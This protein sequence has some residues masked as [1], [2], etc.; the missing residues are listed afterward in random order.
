MT[1]PTI[2]LTCRDVAYAGFWNMDECCE[3]CHYDKEEF[4]IEMC[5]YG[6]A[7]RNKRRQESRFRIE[8]CCA[9]LSGLRKCAES[10]RDIVA[11]AAWGRH[12]R[13]R[14]WAEEGEDA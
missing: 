12:E 3:T 4:D 7:P 2:T 6:D 14:A 13:L 1:R 8:L 11:A 5:E 9:C 10:T